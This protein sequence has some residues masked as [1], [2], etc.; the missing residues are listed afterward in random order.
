MDERFPQRIW[1]AF[2]ALVE[3]EA[4]DRM[5]ERKE[6]E[7][8]EALAKQ[9]ARIDASAKLPPESKLRARFLAGLSAGTADHDAFMAAYADELISIGRMAASE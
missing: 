1:S 9:C 3:F 7:A 4:G 6:R 5:D 2:K 8:L